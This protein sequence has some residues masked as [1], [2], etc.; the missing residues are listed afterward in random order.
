M[1]E[2]ARQSGT[3]STNQKSRKNTVV[4]ENYRGLFCTALFIALKERPLDDFSDLID[5]QKKNGLNIFEGKN[6]VNTCGD[7]IDYLADTLREDLKQDYTSFFVGN[8]RFAAEKKRFRKGT[9][10]SKSC[11]S[12]KIS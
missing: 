4:H 6:H 11:R 9:C 12:R 5:L 7:L 8:G 3:C 10:L 2:T 1:V